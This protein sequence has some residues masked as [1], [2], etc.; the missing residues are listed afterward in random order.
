MVVEEIPSLTPSNRSLPSELLAG[1]SGGP[2]YARRAKAL[3]LRGSI[4][5]CAR[6]IES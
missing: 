6:S 5:T 2:K 1:S 3:I 4:S